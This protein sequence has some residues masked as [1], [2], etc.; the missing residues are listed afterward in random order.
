MQSIL[1][2]CRR[3][4]GPAPR[5]LG[6]WSARQYLRTTPP[7]RLR[8]QPLHP[9]WESYRHERQLFR[10]GVIVW[11]CL[12]T[13]HERLYQEGK[14]DYPA[15]IIYYP[16]PV[17]DDRA[18]DLSL[19]GLRL[20][21]LGG[22]RP[23]DPEACRFAEML[24][25]VESC[26]VGIPLPSSISGG[27]PCCS[28]LA[29]VHRKHLPDRML[30]NKTVPLLILPAVTPAAVILPCRYWPPALLYAWRQKDEE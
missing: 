20:Q 1:D 12:V 25:D 2:D 21:E 17:F 4:F 11:G 28:T 6:G 8:W 18:G 10:E 7:R 23:V 9:L 29:M 13:A 3:L 27:S 14:V 30:V 24:D 15:L 19:L 16:D 22:T 5:R 26:G